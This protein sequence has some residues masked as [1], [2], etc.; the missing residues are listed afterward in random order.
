MD[1]SICGDRPRHTGCVGSK[2]SGHGES[3]KG[4]CGVGGM[5]WDKV[6]R[7]K[8]M[9]EHYDYSAMMDARE[10]GVSLDGGDVG[11][12]MAERRERLGIGAQRHPWSKRREVSAQRGQRPPRVL[13]EQAVMSGRRPGESKSARDR[14][15]ARSEEHTSELPSLL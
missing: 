5:N 11:E 3:G 14:R 9:I 2:A 7:E 15:I 10:R 4:P 12:R 1:F 13:G 8:P 6:R